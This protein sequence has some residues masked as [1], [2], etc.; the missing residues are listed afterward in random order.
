[1]YQTSFQDLVPLSQPLVSELQSLYVLRAEYEKAENVV[2]L[3][4]IDWL[5]ANGF[6]NIRR[7]RADGQSFTFD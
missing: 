2:F 3:N 5:M 6:R 1:M 7:T 4:K